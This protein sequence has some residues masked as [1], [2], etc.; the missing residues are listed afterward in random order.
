MFGISMWELVLVGV[1]LFLVVGPSKLPGL[2]KSIGQGIRDLRRSLNDIKG[3][4]DKD[5]EFVKAVKEAK[6]SVAEAREAVRSIF[7]E[8]GEPKAREEDYDPAP[9]PV[10]KGRPLVRPP[11]RAPGEGVSGDPGPALSEGGP[12]ATFGGE[13]GGLSIG[14]SPKSQEPSGASIR[15]ETERMASAPPGSAAAL[16]PGAGQSPKGSSRRRMVR[17]GR[18]RPAGGGSQPGSG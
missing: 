3:T 16:E 5:D 13:E 11:R 9:R 6:Q 8:D 18:S 14:E 12:G 2:A 15:K 7:D 1:I 17:P 4:V 10:P